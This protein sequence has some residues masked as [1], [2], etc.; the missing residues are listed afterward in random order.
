VSI[1]I[2]IS[3]IWEDTVDFFDPIIQFFKDLWNNINHFLLQ[4]M[5]QDVLNVLVFGIVITFILIIVL[6]IMNRN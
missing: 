1:L 6:A 5:S 4:Y 2:F 3:D